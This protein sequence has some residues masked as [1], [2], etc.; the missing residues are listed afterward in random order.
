MLREDIAMK[1]H[2]PIHFQATA[3]AV[4]RLGPKLPGI[5]RE[6]FL[7][8]GRIARGYAIHHHQFRTVAGDLVAVCSRVKTTGVIE[9]EIDLGQPGLP[10]R[11]F[12]REEAALAA[13]R[14]V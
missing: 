2:A 11:T 7:D 6:A 12:T 9:I 8:I 14:R 4:A 13:R 1:T 10:A 5:A 3:A